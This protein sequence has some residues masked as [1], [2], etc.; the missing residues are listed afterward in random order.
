M[1][2][3]TSA[4]S[5]SSAAY[6]DSYDQIKKDDYI[7]VITFNDG[8]TWTNLGKVY[9]LTLYGNNVEQPIS[10][11]FVSSLKGWIAVTQEG[12]GRISV[13]TDGGVE[14]KRIESW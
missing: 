13:S 2:G 10:L 3:I 6:L 5:G 4:V 9:E 12:V 1:I 7:L 14:W 8:N 11:S